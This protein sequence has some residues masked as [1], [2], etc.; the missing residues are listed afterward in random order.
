MAGEV[1]MLQGTKSNYSKI[2]HNMNTLYF[3]TDTQQLYL[4][5]IE[6]TSS[7]TVLQQAP[8]SATEGVNG[9][10]YYYDGIIYICIVSGSGTTTSYRYRQLN[11]GYM[12][13]PISQT[14]YDNLET[15][16]DN[17]LYIIEV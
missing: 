1:I 10:L 8:T 17:T 6:F 12:I 5:D 14:E 16:D 4:G 13:L 3:C 9:R 11:S 2:F 15:K 7:V